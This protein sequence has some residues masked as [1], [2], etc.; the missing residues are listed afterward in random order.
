MPKIYFNDN[1][2]IYYVNIKDG[3]IYKSNGKDKKLISKD[4]VFT[5]DMILSGMI[6]YNNF[7][8]YINE[9]NNNRLYR[10]DKDGKEKICLTKKSLD[11]SDG[12]YILN[13]YIYYCSNFNIYKISMDGKDTIINSKEKE[14]CT[15]YFNSFK[16]LIYN[17]EFYFLKR[18]G[19]YKMSLDGTKKCKVISGGIYDFQVFGSSIFYINEKDLCLYKDGVKI[20]NNKIL[21]DTGY[22][23]IG[24]FEINNGYI[25]YTNADDDMNLYKMKINENKKISLNVKTVS[26]KVKDR[27]YYID[28]SQKKRTF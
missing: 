18:D 19:I 12:F 20:V 10:I 5:D 24:N 13:G 17:D 23:W 15:M 22:E 16:K 28:S 11:T 1:G 9:N 21:K 25:F 8:Y 14:I 3:Y 7:I 4:R 6:V 2:Y 27:I 26:F